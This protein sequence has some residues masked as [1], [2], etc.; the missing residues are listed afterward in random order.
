[1]QAQRHSKTRCR[2]R[3]QHRLKTC[4]QARGDEV[5][6]G[7]CAAGPCG[8]VRGIADTPNSARRLALLLPGAGTGPGRKPRL[9]P[10]GRGRVML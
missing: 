4:Q 1:M 6:V 10:A 3:G 2:V 9:R 7:F 5:S 8:Q